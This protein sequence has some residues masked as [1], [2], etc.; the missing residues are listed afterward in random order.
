[1]TLEVSISDILLKLSDYSDDH[2]FTKA[3][4]M[5]SEKQKIDTNSAYLDLFLKSYYEIAPQGRLATI[6]AGY[7]LQN[8]ISRNSTNADVEYV[9]RN[10]IYKAILNCFNVIRNRIDLAGYIKPEMEFNGTER[11]TVELNGVEDTESLRKLLQS[12]GNLEFWETFDCRNEGII[13]YIIAVDRK[14]KELKD[15][16]NLT[17]KLNQDD[18]NMSETMQQNI[19]EQFSLLSILLLNEDVTV[20]K[21][22]AGRAHYSDT[23][24][25]NAMLAIPQASLLKPKNLRFLWTNKPVGQDNMFYELMAIKINPRYG[26]EAPLTGDAIVDAEIDYRFEQYLVNIKMNSSGAKIWAQLTKDNI[27]REIAVVVDGYVYCYPVVNTEITGGNSQIT[28]QFTNQ[29]AD[30][31]VNILKSGRMYAPVHIIKEEVYES[32]NK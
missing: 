14:I 23:A 32:E 25:I 12:Q 15:T 6:F 11:I 26:N 24:Q 9:L 17:G 31:F 8:Q 2:D 19:T 13:Q 4:Q 20:N 30:D 29:E 7:I 1:M 22:C 3:L 10:E 16:E 27:G 21:A 28:G 5:A 18:T